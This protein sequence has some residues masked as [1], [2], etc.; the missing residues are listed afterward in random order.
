MTDNY[1][2]NV[3]MVYVDE[4]IDT[5]DPNEE[6]PNFVDIAW[7]I[8]NWASYFVGTELKEARLF[9]EFFGT[10][11]RAVEILWELI[12]CNKLRPRGGAPRASALGALFYEGV[13][14]AGPGLLGR[15]RICRRCQPEDPPQMGL[16]IRQGHCQAP[17]RGGEF[18]PNVRMV[19]IVVFFVMMACD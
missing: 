17:R 2:T 4:S 8:H 5:S 19:R 6:L 11:V 12:V 15:W 18:T 7:N 10:S 14:Q 3:T 9:G 16:G 13:P 1:N